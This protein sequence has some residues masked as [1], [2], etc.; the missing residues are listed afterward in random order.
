MSIKRYGCYADH[1][2]VMRE[3]K[4]GNWVEWADVFESEAVVE[5]MARAIHTESCSRLT[6]TIPW[7]QLA[8]REKS[9]FMA[10]ARAAIQAIAPKAGT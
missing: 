6:L 1:I 8:N 4:N 7:D 10:Y 9:C 5:E 3:D 2:E